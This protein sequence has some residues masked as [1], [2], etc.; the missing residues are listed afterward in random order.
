MKFLNILSKA[1]LFQ[2]AF[3]FLI[4]LIFEPLI[5]NSIGLGLKL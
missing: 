2:C 1:R 5:N 3:V 4:T